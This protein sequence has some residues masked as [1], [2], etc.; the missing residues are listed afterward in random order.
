[1][2]GHIDVDEFLMNAEVLAEQLL[3]CNKLPDYICRIIGRPVT[4][5]SASASKESL[6][7]GVDNSTAP[8]TDDNHSI[9]MPV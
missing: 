1:M 8:H 4:D 9:C 3:T 7:L 2:S 6:N 5:T